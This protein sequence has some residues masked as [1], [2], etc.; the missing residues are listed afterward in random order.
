MKSLPFQL[1]ASFEEKI[2]G[3]RQL[4]PWFRSQ[5]A[6]I[7]EVWFSMPDG[8]PLPILVKFLFTS[9]RLSVQVH[10]GDNYARAH[11]GCGGKAEMWYI[12]AAEPGAMLAAGFRE[13]LTRER[14]RQAAI[15]G[16][17]EQLLQWWPVSPGQVYY[18][19]PGTVHALG[20]GITLCEIQQ[21]NRITYRL[22]DHGRPREL[23]LDKA[24][25][26]ARIEPHPGPLAPEGELLVAC[27]YFVTQ[28]MELTKR[29]S[30][31]DTG[32]WCLLI[33]LD[34]SGTIGEERFAPGQVW[35]VPEDADPFTL[36]SGERAEVLK[37][38]VPS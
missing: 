28:R 31:P 34:G 4:E 18:L 13:P 10:P 22:Y 5:A 33:A 24:L 6:R 8:G 38:Y 23:H 27:P 20:A 36:A 1:S 12:L 9:D 14:A 15:S 19:P 16:E 11:E 25:D 30:W 32:R 29:P 21:N 7:G 35:C 2:W 37:T 26:V 3:V 17:I